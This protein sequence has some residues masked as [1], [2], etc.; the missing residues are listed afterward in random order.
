MMR[1]DGLEV[2]AR[3]GAGAVIA[4]LV[5][6]GGVL[7]GGVADWTGVGR[8]RAA[9][10]AATVREAGAARLLSAAGARSRE[11]VARP[12]EPTARV[13]VERLLELAARAQASGL[14]LRELG[15]AP[16]GA[17]AKAT[18]SAADGAPDERLRLVADGGF[19]AIRAFLAGLAS[20]PELVV[21]AVVEVRRDGDVNRLETGLDVFAT[22][23]PGVSDASGANGATNAGARG[24]PFADAG[25]TADADGARSPAGA[26]RLVGVLRDARRGLALFEGDG[27]AWSVGAGE[28]IGDE[29]VAAIDLGGVT[30]NGRGTARRVPLH[31]GGAG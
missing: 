12:G 20:L 24:D 25:L 19:G 14:Q 29:Q 7:A 3:W 5:C 21:P 15:R 31:D 13:P 28:R 16:A 6:A 11:T 1:A 18:R 10:A 17:D 30:L 9:L 27:A 4:A 8:E 2:A 22:L 26:L 23:L